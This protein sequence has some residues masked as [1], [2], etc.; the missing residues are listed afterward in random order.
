MQPTAPAGSPPVS[1]VK[2][3]LRGV[4]HHLA[5]YVAAIAT[6][7]LC[8][9][10]ATPREL[11]PTIVYGACMTTL[12]AISA[13]YHI[14]TWRPLQRQRMRR[15][16][17]AAIYLQIAGTYTPVCLLALPA[18]DGEPLLWAIWLAALAGIAKSVLW[19]NAPKPV[20]A[21]LY[22]AMGWA[23]ITR[24]QSVA[25]ALEPTGLG[26]LLGGGALYTLGAL[27]YALRRPDPLPELFGYHEIFHALV[28]AA[29]AC[30][31]VMVA[32]IVD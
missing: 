14:P 16:D 27:I 24:W 26:L 7:G 30:H 13:T 25:Q 2:P 32:R 28:V 15:L 11:W 31:F 1:K 8:L 22:V 23:V 5:S 20:S 9:R 4:S 18:N 12:F 6:T 3:R 10:A 19:V 29:A 17:H 21:A